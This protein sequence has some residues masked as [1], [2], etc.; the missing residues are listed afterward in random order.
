MPFGCHDLSALPPEKIHIATLP[1]VSLSCLADLPMA[2]AL[3]FVLGDNESIRYIGRATNLR[4]RWATHHRRHAYQSSEGYMLAWLIVSD[5]GL[6]PALEEACIAYFA[7]LDN[8]TPYADHAT[9]HLKTSHALRNRIL[10]KLRS[11]GTTMQSFFTDLIE[12]LDTDDQLL[13]QL[14]KERHL[15]REKRH[16]LQA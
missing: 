8:G 13:E 12:L 2:P 3:Y 4:S 15:F 16:A 5:E 11:R 14:D 1:C 6:L 7:P 9:I 10:G